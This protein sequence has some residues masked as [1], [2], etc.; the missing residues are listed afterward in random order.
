[1]PNE[2]AFEK[3]T[4][5]HKEII[6]SWLAEPHV[7][8]FW[9]NSQAHKD[10][11]LNFMGGRATPSTYCDGKMVYW[12]ASI[13]E[14]PYAMLMT[15]Q[16]DHNTPINQEKLSR[17][18]KTGHTYGLDYM[19]GN[20]EFLGKGYGV[21]TLIEFLDFFRSEVDDQADTFLIDPTTDNHRAKHV[22]ESAG[23]IYIADFV[24]EGACN[25]S[26]KPHYL[27]IKKFTDNEENPTRIE[28]VTLTLAKK[29]IA[30]QFP[31][32]AHLPVCE[33]EQQGHDNRTYRI[34]KDMLIRLPTAESY[35]LKVPIEQALL[36]KL[37]KHLNVAIPLPI[38]V[39]SPSDDYPYPFSIYKWL[40]G[41]SANHVELDDKTLQKLAFELAA[42]LKELQRITDVEGPPPGQH[43]W[44]RGDHISVYD[45]SAREQIANLTGIINIDSALALWE[46]ACDIQWQKKPVWIHGDFSAG[47][48]LIKDNRL[49]GIIDFGGIAMGDPACDLVITWTYLSG[50]ARD[51]FKRE[52]D[53]DNDTWLRARAWALWKAT[54]ELS[55][56]E[57]KENSEAIIQKKIIKSVLNDKN[58]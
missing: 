3:A 31:E 4:I 29:L 10:D 50:K 54:Y 48:I 20:T 1:M 47:N 37:A 52:I 39:G 19:I 9:D 25:G 14:A 13:N 8:E 34:G 40:E 16:L 23:F 24:M 53:L 32:Y 26:G 5:A 36:P 12:V 51:I 56:F 22:Y 44:W 46:S 28:L 57:D 18:S 58:T 6:F 55:K 42:F 45:K 41:K 21:K 30:S 2:I 49:S 33:V 27:L 11:I 17:L 43:N 7:Q 35:A 15:E 38:K